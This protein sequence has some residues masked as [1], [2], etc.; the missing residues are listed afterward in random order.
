METIQFHPTQATSCFIKWLVKPTGGS[1][2][3]GPHT[4]AQPLF[5]C[6][7]GKNFQEE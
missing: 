7:E 5:M 2:L 1:Y 6:G 3:C 4:D